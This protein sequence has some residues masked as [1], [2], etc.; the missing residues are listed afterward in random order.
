MTRPFSPRI[1]VPLLTGCAL[2]TGAARAD[3]AAPL[4]AAAQPAS[5][6][7]WAENGV[8]HPL[9]ES[10]GTAKRSEVSNALGQQMSLFAELRSWRDTLRGQGSSARREFSGPTLGREKVKLSI[11]QQAMPANLAQWNGAG[12]APG[13]E[14]RLGMFSAGTT[15]APLELRKALRNFD[16]AMEDGTPTLADENSLTWLSMKP[17]SEKQGQVEFAMARGRRDLLAGEGEE[18]VD[19]VALSAKGNWT[20]PSRWSLKGD[21]TQSQ[22]SDQAEGAQAWQ[23]SASGPLVHPWGEAKA[24]ASFNATDT[25]YES[26]SDSVA[27]EGRREGRV[28]VKQ[29]VALGP[30]SGQMSV[31]ASK[32][33]R[34]GAASLDEGTEAGNQNLQAGTNFRVALRP[35][36]ALVG[37]GSVSAKATQTIV[38]GDSTTDTTGTD[39]TTAPDTITAARDAL[40]TSSFD[41]MFARPWLSNARSDLKKSAGGDVGVELALS[42]NLALTV[43]A[44]HSRIAETTFLS[45]SRIPESLTGENRL[46]VEL[47]NKWGE[48]S[49]GIKVSRKSWDDY[50]ISNDQEPDQYGTMLSLQAERQLIGPIRLRTAL[51]WARHERANQALSARRAQAQFTL[52]SLGNLN[53]SYSDGPMDTFN[54]TQIA[55]ADLTRQMGVSYAAGSAAGGKGFG[56]A[57]EYSC[58]RTNDA[59]PEQNWRVGVTYR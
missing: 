35:G 51:D 5:P 10:N 41:G 38:A 18:F 27:N 15:A 31:A 33:A 3:D 2:A 50:W 53:L 49:W 52:A 16:A 58:S 20:L 32:T 56:L 37:S 54:L 44:G 57:V 1:A 23:V 22:L 48:G 9:F 43:S 36:L 17:I 25:G 24:S 13:A 40:Y 42:R 11:G 7:L 59:N 28:S 55:T 39:G 6:A 34:P 8:Q 29:D 12:D 4:A 47:R 21:W 26:L 19:G 30:V 45:D 46:G 14:V